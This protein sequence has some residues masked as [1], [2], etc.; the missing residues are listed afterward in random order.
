MNRVRSSLVAAAL[1][2]LSVLAQPACDDTGFPTVRGG[3]RL[4]V[5]LIDADKVAATRI[6]PRPLKVNTPEGFKIVVRALDAR[7]NLDT[8]YN[9]FVRISSKPGGIDRINSPDADGRNL[10]LTNGVSPEVEIFVSNAFGA[11]FIL[12]E[13]QGYAPADPVATPPPACA[14]GLDNDGDGR[15]DFPADEGC[16]FAN[17]NSEELGSYATG[18]TQPIYYALPRIADLKGLLCNEEGVCAGTGKSPYPREQLLIDTGFHDREDGSQ[19]FDF[20]LVVTRIASDGFFV[21]DTKDARGGFNSIFA[22]NFNAP[23][24]MRVCDR[25][26]TFSGT[27]AEFFGQTQI[28]YPT[29]TLEAWNPERRPCLVPEPTVFG[30]GDLIA[31]YNG[32]GRLDVGPLLLPNVGGL[33]RVLTDSTQN[34]EVRVTSKFGPGLVQKDP[35][36]QV[37]TFTPEASNCDFDGDGRISFAPG[38]E[39]GIC[40]SACQFDPDCTEY[41]N[42]AGRSTFRFFVRNTVTNVAGAIQADATVSTEFKPLERKGQ[43]IKSFTGT[44]TFFSGGSQYTIEARCPDDIVADVNASPVPMDKACVAPR[45]DLDENPQ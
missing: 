16:A 22:F 44:M 6:R 38:S 30:P 31:D 37:Y 24:R 8:N 23:P 26:K 32:D 35:T 27:A 21:T 45:T 4:T 5:E 33:V 34:V 20:D 36:T 17:D 14:D 9:G 29:W 18:A 25:L 39:E 11:T 15:V 12:A 7:G 28:G 3:P 10:R 41:S 13:D 42:F 2:T 1:F 40:S 43:P 19:R